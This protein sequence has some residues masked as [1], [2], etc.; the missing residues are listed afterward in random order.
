M[1]DTEALVG[2]LFLYLARRAETARDPMDWAGEQLYALVAKKLED[3]PALRDLADEAS[4]GQGAISRVTLQRMALALAAATEHD[5]IFVRALAIHLQTCEAA[6]AAMEPARPEDADTAAGEPAFLAGY[7]RYLDPD[8]PATL[9]VGDSLAS[10]LNDPENQRAG[11]DLVHSMVT[12]C[13]NPQNLGPDHPFTQTAR[14]HLA[15]F[16][17]LTGHPAAA[18]AAFEALLTDCILRLGPEHPVVQGSNLVLFLSGD[19]TPAAATEAFEALLANALPAIGPEHPAMLS[20]RDNQASLQNGLVHP[21]AVAQALEDPFADFL[22]V[23]GPE[24]AVIL[25]ARRHLGGLLAWA[26]TPAA[27]AGALKAVLADCLQALG[28]DHTITRSANNAFGYWYVRAR[29]A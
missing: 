20:A 21:V 7:V 15:R 16:L 3:D 25:N 14:N 8:N 27:A 24:H 12:D 10:Y 17:G 23:L 22:R 26:A 18:S 2:Y 4:A 1:S 13:A 9:S 11:F 6:E 29:F 19:V 28:P 5:P